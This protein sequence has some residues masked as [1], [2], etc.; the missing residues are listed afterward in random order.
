[1]DENQKKLFDMIANDESIV[2]GFSK[3]VCNTEKARYFGYVDK[4]GLKDLCK[5]FNYTDT[6]SFVK[7]GITAAVIIGAV[8]FLRRKPEKNLEEKEEHV[9]ENI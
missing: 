9:D 7:G 5:M 6:R 8:N 1:M 3:F 2:A 4:D